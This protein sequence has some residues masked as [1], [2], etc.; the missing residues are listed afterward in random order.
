MATNPSQQNQNQQRSGNQQ[1][2]GASQGNQQSQESRRQ[3]QGQS[4]WGNAQQSSSSDE[5]RSFSGNWPARSSQGTSSSKESG[6]IQKTG[7]LSAGSQEIEEEE[8]QLPDSGSSGN[9]GDSGR[10]MN[11]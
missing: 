6:N 10:R 3:G 5:Q 9:R 7:Q 8:D 2:G 4:Q 11:S 1:Q